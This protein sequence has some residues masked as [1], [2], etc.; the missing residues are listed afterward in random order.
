MERLSTVI[1]KTHL[2]LSMKVGYNIEVLEF[3]CEHCGIILST[4]QSHKHHMVIKHSEKV[5]S[6]QCSKCPT[7]CNRL[8]NI[9]RMVE[10][11]Q[12]KPVLLRH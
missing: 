4:K 10:N 9:R 6:H 11:I 7:T 1:D 5:S 12:A 3:L 8:D 2:D